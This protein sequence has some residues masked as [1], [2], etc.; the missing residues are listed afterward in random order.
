VLKPTDGTLRQIDTLGVT[1]SSPVAPNSFKSLAERHSG[2][3]ALCPFA[4]LVHVRRNKPIDQGW[5]EVGIA[6]RC[7]EA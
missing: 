6:T 5:H 1:G 7:P 3:P 4:V 2:V